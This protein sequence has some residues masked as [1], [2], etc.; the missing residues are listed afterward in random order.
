MAFSFFTAGNGRAGKTILTAIFLLL[1][2]DVVMY[3]DGDVVFEDTATSAK[4]VDLS[5]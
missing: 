3:R 1:G 2:E 5:R 4:S